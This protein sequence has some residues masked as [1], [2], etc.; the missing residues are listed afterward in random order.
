M[1]LEDT[2]L[3]YLADGLSWCGEPGSSDLNIWSCPD[4]KKDCRTNYLSVFWE[5]LSERFAES[6]CNTV[7]VVLN[8]SL[9]NA[10]DSMRY[11]SLCLRWVRANTV[12]YWLFRL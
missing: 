10:F 6:A 7:R 8:G 2:L 11:L 12:S 5:V 4:W 9:E 1:T 3:G